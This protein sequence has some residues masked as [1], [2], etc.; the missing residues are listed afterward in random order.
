MNT[1]SVELN[2]HNSPT[3]DAAGN[4]RPID[5]TTFI[6]QHTDTD[7]DIDVLIVGSGYGAAMAL[8]GLVGQHREGRPLRIV[9]LERGEAYGRGDFPD[10]FADLAG[11]IR[12]STN[13]PGS[14]QR[15]FTGRAHGLFDLRVGDDLNVLLANGL[16][17]GSLINAGVMA[18][19]LPEVMRSTAWPQAIRDDSQWPARFEQVRHILGGISSQRFGRRAQ[20]MSAWAGQAQPAGTASSLH[21]TVRPDCLA[22]GDCFT[23]CNH[24]A[25]LSLDR[26]VIAGALAHHPQGALHVVTG[27]TVLSVQAQAPDDA[28]TDWS[29]RVAHTRIPAERQS[30][31]TLRARTVIVAAGA[32]GS[33]ELLMKSAP[34]RPASGLK[35]GS[36]SPL[37]RRFSGNGDGLAIVH[38]APES[39]HGTA[40]PGSKPDERDVGPTITRCIDLR[41]DKAE[42]MVVQDLGVPV[43]WHRVFGE[44]TH[45]M[46]ALHRLTR[47]DWRCHTP[48]THHDH[49]RLPPDKAERSMLVALI[50]HDDANGELRLREHGA[51]TQIADSDGWLTVHWPGLGQDERFDKRFERFANMVTRSARSAGVPAAKVLNNPLY[52]PLPLALEDI[53]NLARGQAR[54]PLTSVHPLGGCAMADTADQGVVNDL[55]QVYMQHLRPDGPYSLA[56]AQAVYRH[57]VVL[58]GAIVPTSLGINPALTIA[59]LAHR[60]MAALPQQWGLTQLGAPHPGAYVAPKHP[61]PP[62]PPVLAAATAAAGVCTQTSTQVEMSESF[63]A[64]L[65]LNLPGFPRQTYL[66]QLE[67]W[68]KPQPIVA[69]TQSG[70][71]ACTHMEVDT[72]RSRLI[73]SQP[74]TSEPHASHE[75]PQGDPPLMRAQISGSMSWMPLRRSA[76]ITRVARGLY[77]WWY[78]RGL[79]ELGDPGATNGLGQRLRQ[80]L[81]LAS[82][83][84]Q[85]R[86]MTYQLRID[87]V[88]REPVGAEPPEAW[89]NATWQGQTIEIIK[90]L[91]YQRRVQPITQ[92][93]QGDLTTFPY[94][95]RAGGQA[96]TIQLDPLYWRHSGIPLF[97]ITHQATQPDALLDGLSLLLFMARLMLPM[98]MW[99]MR[100]PRLASSRP[101]PTRPEARLPALWPDLHCVRHTVHITPRQPGQ[102]AAEVVLTRMRPHDSTAWPQTRPPVLLIHGY[103]ASGSTFSHPALPQ[104]GLGTWLARQG[105]DV[106]V[107][108]MRCSAGLSTATEPWRFAQMGE[109][110]IPQAMQFVLA[111][112]GAPTLDVVAHCMGAAMLTLGL[113]KPGVWSSLGYQLRNAP[114]RRLVLSQV[115][116]AMKISPAN[117][118]RA[119]LTTLLLHYLPLGPWYLTLGSQAEAASGRSLRTNTDDMLDRLL[120]LV[121]YPDEDFDRMNPP[122]LCE[123]QGPWVG[124][125]RRMDVLYGETFKLS[126]ISDKVLAHLHELFGP[127]NLKTL[128]DVLM[129]ANTRLVIDQDGQATVSPASIRAH[130]G[131]MD[132]IM[133]LHGADNQLVSPATARYLTDL[134]QAAGIAHQAHVID[135]MGHQD[136]LIGC[137]APSKVFERIQHFLA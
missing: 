92:W 26:T 123:H 46:D 79:N 4:N 10:R 73:I 88:V 98:Q 16:G 137:D 99:A 6:T 116:P 31:H 86:A 103:S 108:D 127:L 110:D 134:F 81:Q 130:M 75:A 38:D 106:W 7:I 93:M 70:P 135:G 53:W 40:P 63:W 119:Y 5:L 117:T 41:T 43:A 115:G 62:Q 33:T 129:Y 36:A 94:L 19:P 22:C 85:R 44:L 58:D 24:D 72:E 77:A 23:G 90:P 42:P 2:G 34:A 125:R 128:S 47:A 8:H 89:R 76:P 69:L 48:A 131:H 14:Q 96:P 111:Q 39:L 120:A 51:D 3:V 32:L 27:A 112:T 84:G 91:G 83:A 109:E 107:L 11:H 54:G 56:T 49:A 9:M 101:N 1:T 65:P 122:H 114:I 118:A 17:G 30:A 87:Q 12:F 18:E 105:A 61:A 82:H 50:G 68:F 66:V 74:K 15:P 45:S 13:N 136:C 100:L 133:S 60:A 67:L 71:D 55:G 29:V 95:A 97:R 52:Q 28:N 113:L 124:M 121:P 78:N 102:P 37:G 21:V 20:A 64:L 57:L 104:G 59:A 80:G 25:K 132:R 126:Q 35:S